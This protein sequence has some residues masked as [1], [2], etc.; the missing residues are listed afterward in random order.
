MPALREP[1][2][3]KPYRFIHRFILRCMAACIVALL[4]PIALHLRY[5]PLIPQRRFLQL[6]AD[7][8]EPRER[9]S[10]FGP[11][12]LALRHEAAAAQRHNT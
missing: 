8:Q 1:R 12:H 2:L 3:D 4:S 6:G 10:R 7:R 5:R 9:H 11:R